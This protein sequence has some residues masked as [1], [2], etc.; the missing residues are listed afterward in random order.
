VGVGVGVVMVVLRGLCAVGV[1]RLDLHAVHWVV[2][3]AIWIVD[4][5][6]LIRE[7][8][9]ILLRVHPN[10]PIVPRAAWAF[11]ALGGV[12]IHTPCES[13]DKTS[14]PQKLH[15]SGTVHDERERERDREIE[16]EIARCDV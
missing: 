16:R 7:M 13:H 2:E 9:H 10:T 1:R 11:L 3:G 4:C 12:A 14:P 15:R 8:E 6:R 5:T